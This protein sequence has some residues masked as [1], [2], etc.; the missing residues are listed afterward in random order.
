VHIKI[1]S[2]ENCLYRIKKLPIGNM[3]QFQLGG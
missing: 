2:S 1:E 3:I